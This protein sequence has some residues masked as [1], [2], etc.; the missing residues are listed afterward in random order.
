MSPQRGKTIT[1][2]ISLRRCKGHEGTWVKLKRKQGN[3][4][5]EINN[6]RLSDN[7][8]ASFTR[9]ADWDKETFKAVWPKQDKDHRKG[10][11]EHRTVE[12]HG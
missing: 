3:K 1:F 5:V 8:R 9:T 12:T 4:F 2:K 7:C 11:S 6:A 10:K